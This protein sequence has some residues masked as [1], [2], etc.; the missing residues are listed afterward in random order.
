MANA[1]YTQA[2]ADIQAGSLVPTTDPRVYL[3]GTDA[4]FTATAKEFAQFDAS[5][6]HINSV[7]QDASIGYLVTYAAPSSPTY[8]FDKFDA[9]DMLAGGDGWSSAFFPWRAEEGWIGAIVIASGTTP[10][11]WIDTVTLDATSTG[12]VSFPIEDVA[13]QELS[14]LWNSS[15]I[16]DA[17][18]GDEEVFTPSTAT[19]QHQR[20]DHYDRAVVEWAEQALRDNLADEIRLLN[21]FGRQNGGSAPVDVNIP[22]S[23]SMAARSDADLAER[24]HRPQHQEGIWIR[25]SNSFDAL[26]LA[27]QPTT[28]TH[29][30]LVMAF[31]TATDAEDGDVPTVLPTGYK[32]A[33]AFSNMV[34]RTLAANL[35]CRD[36]GVFHIANG[37]GQKIQRA[38]R[39]MPDTHVLVGTYTVLQKTYRPLGVA[40]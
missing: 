16:F 39:G 22:V 28:T 33:M 15:G 7:V 19:A 23:P 10:I 25:V 8:T 3:I 5:H 13:G 37:G 26:G 14:I 6:T 20:R 17:G 32:R 18:V 27:L 4:T 12:N 36:Y 38:T 24:G 31:V 21:E 40:S 1:F 2:L 9:A 11:C 35:N 34:Y 29:T 30:L